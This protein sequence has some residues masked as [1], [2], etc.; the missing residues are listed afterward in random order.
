LRRAEIPGYRHDAIEQGR[1]RAWIDKG[2]LREHGT[3][4]PS[5]IVGHLFL[6]DTGMIE[7]GITKPVVESQ[8]ELF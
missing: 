3:D 4:E 1:V 2:Y 6:T 7:A 8:G 5:A